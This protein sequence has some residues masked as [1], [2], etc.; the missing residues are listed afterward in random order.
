VNRRGRRM[1]AAG[2]KAGIRSVHHEA[3]GIFRLEIYLSASPLVDSLDRLFC[4]WIAQILELPSEAAPL[5]LA[6]GCKTPFGAVEGQD[7]PV[8]FTVLSAARA[9]A[10]LRLICGICRTCAG[11]RSPAE[12]MEIARRQ[13]GRMWP[14]WKPIDAAQFF[15]DGGRA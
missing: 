4:D 15:S 11:D 2:R 8:A 9:D 5:C 1:H 13:L 6:A 10:K 14:D 3:S 12:I 7:Y